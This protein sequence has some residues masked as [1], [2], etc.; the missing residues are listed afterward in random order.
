MVSVRRETSAKKLSSKPKA[1]ASSF[2]SQIDETSVDLD[3]GIGLVIYGQEGVGKTSLASYAPDPLFIIDKNEQGIHRLKKRK[4]VPSTVKVGPHVED[5][6]TLLDACDELLNSSHEYSTI[7]FDSLTGY[8]R[9]CFD[10]CCKAEYNNDFTS[11]GFFSFF[12]G[13]RTAAQNWWPDFINRLTDLQEQNINVI[14]LAHSAVK[15]VNNPA[16]PDYDKYMPDLD[17]V[18]WSV[19]SKWAGGVLYYAHNIDISKEKT[20]RKMKASGGSQRILYAELDGGYV[21]KNS[22]NLPPVLDPSDSA[23]ECW[24]DLWERINP[25]EKEAPRKKKVRS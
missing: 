20:E 12:Q 18:I 7:V 16:G 6:N 5:W 14:L 4:L 2:L 10:A 25:V 23:E 19:T 11:T 13:P 1:K 8:Q 17:K 9:M 15:T 24:R 21:A 3:V 22:Y